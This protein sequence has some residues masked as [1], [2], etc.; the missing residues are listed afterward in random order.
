MALEFKVY[1]P[2]KEKNEGKRLPDRRIDLRGNT[3]YVKDYN[4]GHEYFGLKC[5]PRTR[6]LLSFLK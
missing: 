4:T 6:R 2:K 1:V 3:V 5:D